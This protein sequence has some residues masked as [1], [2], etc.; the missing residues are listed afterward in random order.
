MNAQ[1]W[2]T[3]ELNTSSWWDIPSRI[4]TDGHR[5]VLHGNFVPQIPA[6]M[7]ARFTQPGDIV[8]DPFTGSGT[9]ALECIRQGRGFIGCELNRETYRE[10]R[11]HLGQQMSFVETELP[12]V[13]L[14]RGDCLGN[15]AIAKV[16]QILDQH[17]KRLALTMVHPPYLDIIRFNEGDPSCLAE[18]DHSQFML[19]LKELAEQYAALSDYKAHLVLVMGDVW[20]SKNAEVIPLGSHAMQSIRLAGWALRGTIVKNVVGTRVQQKNANLWKYRCLKHGT[21]T[22]EHEYVFVFRKKG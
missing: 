10:T 15:K 17:D 18:M 19:C 4:K 7:I 8:A 6:E 3:C 1:D 14:I 16:E 2:R 21:Y 22:F 11:A 9:T 20:D 12:L 13:R 5:N